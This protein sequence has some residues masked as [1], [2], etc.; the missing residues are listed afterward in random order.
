MD[1]CILL[2]KPNVGKTS[3]LL[4]FAEF[5]GLTECSL[6][7]IDFLGNQRK[8][9]YS[10]RDAKNQLISAT[11]F[12]TR[13]ICKIHLSIPVYKGKAN[14]VLID[15]GGLIDGISRDESVRTSMAETLKYLYLANI[16]IHMIDT[17]SVY[18]KKISTFSEIDYQINQYGNS[19]GSYCILANK[20]DLEGGEEGLK[21]LKKEFK[22]TYI[23][24]ISAIN[25]IGFKEVKKFVARNI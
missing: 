18:Q 21:F 25:K 4:N 10:I 24:P 7:F 19:R 20:I 17:S 14:I 11:P 23:I 12:K 13:E 16:I 1:N 3:F 15:T 22:D 8:E 5:L 9:K 2:G 6:E